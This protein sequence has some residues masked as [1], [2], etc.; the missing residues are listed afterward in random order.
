MKRVVPIRDFRS[1]G[2]PRAANERIVAERLVGQMFLG[3]IQEN[4]AYLQ[5]IRQSIV[6][7]TAAIRAEVAEVRRTLRWAG[8]QVWEAGVLL[9]ALHAFQHGKKSKLR[10]WMEEHYGTKPDPILGAELRGDALR[11]ED[12]TDVGTILA[13][14]RDLLD[15]QKARLADKAA[16]DRRREAEQIM[17]GWR[18]YGPLRR[19][20]DQYDDPITEVHRAMLDAESRLAPGDALTS[21]K[22][23]NR[24]REDN[25]P[26]RDS[27]DSPRRIP[28]DDKDV[29]A[30]DINKALWHTVMARDERR[31]KPGQRIAPLDDLPELDKFFEDPHSLAP[32]EAVHD[33]LL[34]EWLDILAQQRLTRRELEV[35]TLMRQGYKQYEIAA[36]L[37][38]TQGRVSQIVSQVYE[39]FAH[40]A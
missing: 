18:L 6:D 19:V 10:T 29:A 17:T 16:R 7:V 32:Y 30:D 34:L 8:K 36:R 20:L 35:F 2:E 11:I 25:A 14:F 39:K 9:V 26:S 3:A 21:G 28:E 23:D 31:L 5:A 15:G 27:V 40:I 24:V 38:I 1:P 12:D 4:G 22:V 13:I 33:R 37:D